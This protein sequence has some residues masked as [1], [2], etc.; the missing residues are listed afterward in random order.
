MS[1][2]VEFGVDNDEVARHWYPRKS[3]ALE[4]A[5]A[6][7][8]PS[9]VKGVRWANV[10]NAR[11]AHVVEYHRWDADRLQWWAAEGHG[12]QARRL[13]NGEDL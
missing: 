3:A 13:P 6:H 4:A 2:C 9:K 7:C 5:Q 1:Y 8:Y 10:C 12:N 11:G